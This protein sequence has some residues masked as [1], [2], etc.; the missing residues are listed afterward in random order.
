M[1]II[2]KTRKQKL[3]E[4]SQKYDNIPRDY[5]DRLNW[6]IDKYNLSPKQMD[7]IIEKKRMMEMYLSYNRFKIILYEDPEGAKRPRFR[8]ISRSNYASAAMQN[9]SFIHVYSPNAA[10]DS[11][12]MHRLV[13]NELVQLMYFI[14]TPCSV[15]INA[16][17]K[18]PSSFNITDTFLAE[19]GLHRQ[20]LKPDFDNIGK[21]Y[22]DMFNENIWLDD[23]LVVSGTVNKFYSI[24]PR[25]EIFIYYMNYATNK[26]QYNNIIN[27]KGYR[28]DYPIQYLDNYGRPTE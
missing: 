2:S 19:I 18:T 28:E 12:Y 26:I 14:Q 8:F 20:Y 21:K 25:V 23:S 17:F 3:S 7:Q 22:P 16:Y 24:L 11:K 15:T 4:Y 27:R 13:E 1:E 10:D 9:P 6:M 5:E